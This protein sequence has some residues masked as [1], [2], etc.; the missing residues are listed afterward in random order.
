MSISQRQTG[1]DSPLQHVPR[2]HRQ[3][4]KAFMHDQMSL[5]ESDIRWKA[6]CEALQR[7]GHEAAS[8]PGSHDFDPAFMSAFA[9]MIATPKSERID[10]REAP[11][12]AFIFVDD[13]NDSNPFGH[14]VG[15]WDHAKVLEE[16]PVVTNDVSDNEAGY[17][18]GNVTVVPLGWFPPHWGDAIQFATLWF[19]AHEIPTVVSPKQDTAK[20]IEQSI[21]RAEGV[22]ELMK[23]ALRD[24][25]GKQHPRHERAIQREIADQRKVI[26]DLRSLLP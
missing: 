4:W 2:D 3:E 8:P 5:P 17:D 20:W 21:V 9:H 10:P 23:K 6:K 19:G 13:P 24:N 22:V 15:K 7:S 16:I 18:A 14:V 26:A 25:D 12:S 11:I 1:Q